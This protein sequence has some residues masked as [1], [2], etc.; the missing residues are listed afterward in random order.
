M[1]LSMYARI[2]A[3]LRARG[4]EHAPLKGIDLVCNLYKNIALRP[5]QDI[6]LLVQ[7]EDAGRAAGHLCEMGLRPLR[8]RGMPERVQVTPFLNSRYFVDESDVRLAVH[9]HWHLLN[10]SVPRERQVRALGVERLWSRLVRDEQSGGLVLSPLDRFLHLCDHALKHSYGSLIQWVDLALILYGGPQVR[11]HV[12]LDPEAVVA[13]ARATGRET[14]VAF[15]VEYVRDL[16]GVPVPPG[17]RQRLRRVP[18]GWVERWF[19]RRVRSGRSTDGLCVLLYGSEEP[20][21][22]SR[23]RFLW[24]SLAPPPEALGAIDLPEHGG[25]PGWRDYAARAGSALR[26]AGRVLGGRAR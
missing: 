15:A 5:M 24:G 18:R 3:V 4:I 23:L 11:R 13:E 9:L 21:W 7:P 12:E 16:L 26:L 6:D 8:G 1:L 2:S 20:D 14:A 25:L 19:D 17:L 10:T 22:R